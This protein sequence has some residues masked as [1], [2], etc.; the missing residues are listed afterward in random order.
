MQFVSGTQYAS[1]SLTRLQSQ[2]S[3]E[4]DAAR[5]IVMIGAVVVAALPGPG[6]VRSLG[7][8]KYLSAL[9]TMTLDWALVSVC[10]HAITARACAMRARPVDTVLEIGR[11]RVSRMGAYPTATKRQPLLARYRQ[12]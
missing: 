12:C 5:R 9:S 3:R 11:R 2:D 7:R 1:Q 6:N 8:E 10:D 4:L